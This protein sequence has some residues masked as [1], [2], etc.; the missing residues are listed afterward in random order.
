MVAILRNLLVKESHMKSC[1][2]FNKR[3]KVFYNGYHKVKPQINQ[4]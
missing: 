3:I 1:F 2:I 4:E